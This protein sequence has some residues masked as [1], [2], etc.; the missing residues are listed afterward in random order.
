MTGEERLRPGIPRWVEAPLA[1]AGLIAAAPLLL[2]SGILV[3]LTSPGPVIF[4]QRRVG[5]NGREFTIYKFRSMKQA[6]GGG[7]QVT[8][9]D[10]ARCTS[11]GKFLRKTKLDELPELWNVAAGDMSFVGPRPEVSKYVD[12]SDPAWRAVL[13]VRPGITDPMTLRLRNEEALLALVEGDRE[14]YYLR[15]L[16]PYKLRGYQEYLRERSFLSDVQVLWRTAVA[17]VFPSA[18]PPPRPHEIPVE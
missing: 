2:L 16:Q 17:V 14:A 18:A 6:S 3:K 7:P 11:V 9:A 12:V 8:A 13:R 1:L 15:R 4:R 5:L 10:D